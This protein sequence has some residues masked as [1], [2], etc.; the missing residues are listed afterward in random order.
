MK[1]SRADAEMA[2]WIRSRSGGE[3]IGAA[4]EV[5]IRE[6]R[7]DP[8]TERVLFDREVRPPIPRDNVLVEG[9]SVRVPWC[10]EDSPP[11][12]KVNRREGTLSPQRPER[13]RRDTGPGARSC[14]TR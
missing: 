13:Q 3:R 6:Y 8:E 2:R 4:A 14:E 5:P 9:G 12:A 7:P 11:G 10:L 1:R